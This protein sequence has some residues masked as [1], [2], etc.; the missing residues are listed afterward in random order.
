MS[1]LLEQLRQEKREKILRRGES[2]NEAYIYCPYCGHE[3]QDTWE[4]GIEPND[5]ENERQCQLESCQRYFMVSAEI[6]FSTRKLK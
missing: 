4:F 2:Y 3:Q 6:R 5:E 1:E